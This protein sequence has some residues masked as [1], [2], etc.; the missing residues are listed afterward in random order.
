M[1]QTIKRLLV[2]LLPLPL[3]GLA[4]AA[5][6][7]L[8]EAAKNQDR[9]AVRALL[10][11]NVDV[12]TAYGDGTTALH[13][14]AYFDDAVIADLLIRGG[15][16]VN[17]VNDLGVTALALATS[18]AMAE[19]LLKAGANP[20]I[21]SS[22]GES[23]LMSAART[24]GVEIVKALLGHGANPNAKEN[25]RG[26]TALMWAAAQNHPDVVRVLLEH[27][28]DVHART[29]TASQLFYTGEA[30]GA[31]R[32]ATD[33]VMRTIDTGGST[34]LMFA[35]RQGDLASARLLLAAGANPNETRADG[36]SP[37]VLASFSGH[38]DF[39]AFLLSKD[40]N[41]NAADVGYA[42]LH[43]A[44]LRGD[45][46]LVKTLLMYG[47]NPNARITKGSPI[48]REGEDWILPT[49]LVGATPFFLAA[50]FLE[51]DIMRAL[52]KA[53]ADP[54][55]GTADGTTPLMAASG[56]GWG[57]GVDRRGRDTSGNEAVINDSDR[58]AEVAKL[59][60]DLGA[61]VNAANEAGDTALHG[62]AAKGYDSIIQALADK[63]AKLD[64][65]N[66]RGR[67]PLSG[68]KKSSADLLRKLG[69]KE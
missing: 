62:A 60:L 35:A 50:K 29:L 27:G 17:K 24:G 54:L 69:A 7:R 57:G 42:A 30:S 12:N 5:D 52:A 16:D 10:Q 32:N 1:R 59:A 37:L 38:G 43:T 41:P 55:L 9:D 26:Q 53:G 6:L 44:V 40:A 18:S 4:A 21:V 28:A 25:V 11:Q 47:A 15:A 61:N 39:A 20:N 23:P 31:G 8:L 36:M 19:Q 45:V 66:K 34:P 13:W 58:A 64:I 67:T 46:E 48:T 63:G 65:Q 68:A 49:P 14:A 22:T 51:I 3:T 56:V 2:C 33:W